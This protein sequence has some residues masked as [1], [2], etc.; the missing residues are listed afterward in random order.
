MSGRALT[1]RDRRVL[2][3]VATQAA[4]LVKR[5]VS[6]LRELLGGAET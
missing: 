1:G 4:G 6:R 5:G 3:V 2:S